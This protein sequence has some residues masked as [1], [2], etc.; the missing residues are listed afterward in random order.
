MLSFSTSACSRRKNRRRTVQKW[1]HWGL[2]QDR[3]QWSAPEGKRCKAGTLPLRHTPIRDKMAEAYRWRRREERAGRGHVCVPA[4]EASSRNSAVGSRRRR[5]LTATADVKALGTSARTEATARG[6]RR[7]GRESGNR[8]ENRIGGTKSARRCRAKATASATRACAIP[9]LGMPCHGTVCGGAL[10]CHRCHFA[11]GA[12]EHG[13]CTRA[14]GAPHARLVPTTTLSVLQ[15]PTRLDARH[16]CYQPTFRAPRRTV[17]CTLTP[18]T[19][20]TLNGHVCR[21]K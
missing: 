15:T 6:D 20:T 1:T 2:K 13:P 9:L 21:R 11:T 12:T 8:H 10:L 19:P 16:C 18:T 14:P 4:N 5:N 17:A 7:D 3:Q